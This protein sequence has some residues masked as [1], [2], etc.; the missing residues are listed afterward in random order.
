MTA[1][2]TIAEIEKRFTVPG[3]PVFGTLFAT[4]EGK[5]DIYSK[6]KGPKF[7]T[8]LNDDHLPSSFIPLLK[9]AGVKTVNMDMNAGK[10]VKDGFY[11]IYTFWAKVDGR[12]IMPSNPAVMYLTFVTAE[13]THVTKSEKKIENY[14]TPSGRNL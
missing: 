8:L 9:R 4:E 5:C 1:K 11:T 6:N 13:K 14:C 12:K 3:C 10:T 2:M 7:D